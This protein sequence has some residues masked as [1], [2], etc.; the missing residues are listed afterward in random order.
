MRKY[1]ILWAL[2]CLF[3]LS[4]TAQNN[5]KIKVLRFSELQKTLQSNADTLYVVNFWATWCKPCV[6]ELPSFEKA[7]QEFKDKNVKI[8][9]VSLDFESDLQ[10]KLVPFVQRKK[11]QPE[12]WLLNE[13]DYNSFIDKVDT[14]WQGAIP[15]TLIFNNARKK[16]HFVEKELKHDELNTLINKYL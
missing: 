16:R 8:L 10:T 7:Y 4:A 9:L 2:V 3:A 6:M 1:G 13:T 5:Q 15:A 11:L 12:V 14:S